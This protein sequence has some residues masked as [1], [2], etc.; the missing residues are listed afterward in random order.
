MGMQFDAAGTLE[1]LESAMAA[2]DG[3]DVQGLL[4]LCCDENG[5]QPEQLDPVLRAC[6]LPVAGGVFPALIHDGKLAKTGSLVLGLARP[7]EVVHVPDLSNHKADFESLIDARIPEDAPARPTLL[8][9]VD[10]FARRIGAFIESLFTIFGL[11]SNFIGGGAGSLSLRRE[12]CLITPDGLVGDGA[13][14]G[15]LDA[16]SGIGVSH[17]WTS[18]EGPFRVTASE[19][20]VIHALEGQPALALYRRVVEAH[21]GEPISEDRFFETAGGHPL[22]IARMENER[23]VRDIL[24]PTEQ[25][26]LRCVGEVPEGV[27]V[28][29]L[30]GDAASLIE[31]ASRARNAARAAFPGTEIGSMD[32]FM[33]CIS[34][35]LFLG[36]RFSEEL[37]AVREPGRPLIGACTIGEIA[38]SGVDFLEFFNKTAVVAALDAP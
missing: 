5:F 16:P 7:F 13:V 10:G 19:G 21:R 1:G 6:S 14:I 33:D 18:L 26:G 2:A 36:D 23:I 27:F 22:G 11:E 4:V 37:A 20:N 8:V 24:R 15:L 28:D 32:L 31:A 34:R 17:G 30:R 25:G 29:V 38:N 3:P 12:P 9:F 35:V